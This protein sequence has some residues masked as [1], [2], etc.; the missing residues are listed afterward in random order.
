VGA[1]TGLRTNTE[2][3]YADDLTEEGCESGKGDILDGSATHGANVV[4][5]GFEMHCE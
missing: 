3:S 5:C 4:N 1:N 2:E